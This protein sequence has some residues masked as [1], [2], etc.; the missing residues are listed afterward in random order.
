M[1]AEAAAVEGQRQTAEQLATNTQA[2]DK[3]DADKRAAQLQESL[4]AARAATV[5]AV[6]V[7]RNKIPSLAVVYVVLE[8][9]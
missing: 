5:Q 8:P 1:R 2:A 4:H 9:V 6:Q 3:L 7:F